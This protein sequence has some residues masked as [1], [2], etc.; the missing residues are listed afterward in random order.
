MEGIPR[1]SQQISVPSEGLL[2][3]SAPQ[4]D[5][6]S[7][8]P[9]TSASLPVRTEPIREIQDQSSAPLEGASVLLRIVD[10]LDQLDTHQRQTSTQLR[11]IR[12]RLDHESAL[13]LASTRPAEGLAFHSEN[14]ALPSASAWLYGPSGISTS[15]STSAGLS[16]WPTVLATHMWRDHIRKLSSTISLAAF[17]RCSAILWPQRT[18]SQHFQDTRTRGIHRTRHRPRLGFLGCTSHEI[19]QAQQCG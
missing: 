19:H 11:S 1:S 10:R 14:S 16:I 3:A 4:Q 9:V 13:A 2:E 17:S 5:P 15:P 8:A 12:Q 18:S 7:V 6:V